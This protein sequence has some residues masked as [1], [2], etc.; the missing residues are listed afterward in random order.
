MP[1]KG[2]YANINKRKKAGKS[3]SKSKST[4][5]PKTYEQMKKKKGPFK[6]KRKKK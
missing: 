1:K 4:I 3:R 2:L 6:P 5:D